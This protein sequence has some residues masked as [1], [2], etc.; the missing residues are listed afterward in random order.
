MTRDCGWGAQY[1][2]WT[3]PDACTC[4]TDRV[5]FPE[6][7]NVTYAFHDD[8]TL[9][10]VN[11]CETPWPFELTC[12]ILWILAALWYYLD[13]GETRETYSKSGA[14]LLFVG[15]GVVHIL[16]SRDVGD[17][18]VASRVLRALAELT[19]LALR[20]RLNPSSFPPLTN[21]A[22]GGLIIATGV[23]CSVSKSLESSVGIWLYLTTAI[24]DTWS[25]VI[26]LLTLGVKHVEPESLGES[27]QRSQKRALEEFR[28]AYF[29]YQVV[30]LACSVV[31][32]IIYTVSPAK[33]LFVV[34]FVNVSLLMLQ[35]Y[36]VVALTPRETSEGYGHIEIEPSSITNTIGQVANAVG[37]AA[38]GNPKFDITDY[39]TDG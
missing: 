18:Y 20:N 28:N 3:A 10:Y 11:N 32:V 12:G 34:S 8:D 19:L 6:R 39:N 14:P 36:A 25:V 29:Y 2:N 17:T 38:T 1:G 24:A 16:R 33:P 27:D 7:A 26:F 9:F 4:Y 35:T 21:R 30:R 37:R 15:M 22:V 23:T 31:A 5:A 13:L